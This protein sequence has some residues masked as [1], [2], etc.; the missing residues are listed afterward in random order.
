MSSFLLTDQKFV[1]LGQSFVQGLSL[2]SALRMENKRLDPTL[3]IFAIYLLLS[4]T[5]KLYQ[6]S[7]VWFKRRYQNNFVCNN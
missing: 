2:F 3:H 1:D 6:A 7:C 4:L 5:D